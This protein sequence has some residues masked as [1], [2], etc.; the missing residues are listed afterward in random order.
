MELLHVLFISISDKQFS[1]YINSVEK[2]ITY[3]NVLIDLHERGVEEPLLFAEDGLPGIEEEIKQICPRSDFQLCTI[4]A[5]RNFLSH[6]RTSDRNDIDSDLKDIFLSKS[7]NEAIKR[8]DDFKNKW[9]S[10]YPKAVYSMENNL[11]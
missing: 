8:F 7:K 2:H 10:K 5:S 3:R 4:H 1:F 6:V 11:E 9:S